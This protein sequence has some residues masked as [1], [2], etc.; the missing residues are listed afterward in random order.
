MDREEHNDWSL[1]YRRSKKH[2]VPDRRKASKKYLEY[3]HTAPTAR[4]KDNPKHI[5]LG[6]QLINELELSRAQFSA[7]QDY[8]KFFLNES[9]IED[10]PPLQSKQYIQSSVSRSVDRKEDGTY[11]SKSFNFPAGVPWI[12][13]QEIK[14]EVH[15]YIF[16]ICF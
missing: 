2:Y 8:V 9:G 4:L 11:R 13:E 1:P 6:M 15:I 14:F 7:V 3:A 12:E 10:A 5:L 16:F